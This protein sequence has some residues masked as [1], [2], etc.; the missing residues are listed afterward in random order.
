MCMCVCVCDEVNGGKVKYRDNVVEKKSV[1]S[2][3]KN[4]SVGG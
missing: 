3:K 1:G 2:V 4:V